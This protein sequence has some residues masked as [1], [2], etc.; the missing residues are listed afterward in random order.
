M[1]WIETSAKTVE[2]AIK[3]GLKELNC[4]LTDVSIE[5]IDQGSPGLFGMFGRLAKVRLTMKEQDLDMSFDMPYIGSSAGLQSIRPERKAKPAERPPAQKPDA[6]A[7][8]KPG[9]TARAEDK[10][11]L[12]RQDFG[13]GAESG[14]PFDPGSLGERGR[15]AYDFLAQVT[16]H[17]GIDADIR[18]AESEGQ[19]SAQITGDSQGIL[20]GRRGDTLDALQ[21]LTSLVVNKR[22]SEYTRVSLDVEH[23]RR[24]RE[25]SLTRLANRMASRARKL[26]RIAMEP[27]N[28]YERR[29]LHSA[30]QGHPFVTTHSEGEEP[31]RRVIITQK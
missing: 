25:E 13:A 24:K 16:R 11:H 2:E 18:A 21:Y 9:P 3:S 17:I 26:G 15:L 28:P 1:K 12:D 31:F 30:L 5:Y 29:I 10:D 23:Y 4:E 20:I 19:I 14:A 8:K 6:R 22:Q 27:M 7:R